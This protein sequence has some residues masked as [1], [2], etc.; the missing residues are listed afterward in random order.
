MVRLTGGHMARSV[1]TGAG[2]STL[3]L[4]H[5][6][7]HHIVFAIDGGDSVSVTQTSELLRP[8]RVEFVDG[9]TQRTLFEYRFPEKLD[10]VLID[11]PHGYPFPEMEYWVLYRHIRQGGL[12]MVDDIHI[13]TINRLFQFLREE[14]MFE[15][16][17]VVGYTAFFRRTAAPT[18]DPYCDGWYEQPFNTARFPVDVAA[19]L[20]SLSTEID[21]RTRL[22]PLVETWNAAGTRVAIFGIGEHTRHLLQA[23][24]EIERLRLVA[25]LDSNPEKQ[26][27]SY[28]G[29]TVR[30]PE[31]AEGN[32]DVVLCSSF[33]HEMTQMA[34]LDH[35]NVK[36]V[37]SHVRSE[38]SGGSPFQTPVAMPA[39]APGA[40][41][42]VVC[43]PTFGY[44]LT[45]PADDR[46]PFA[47][48]IDHFDRELPSMRAF[49]AEVQ[50][51]F[52]ELS[53]I[54]HD[55]VDDVTP[56]WNNG[57]FSWTDA[58]LAYAMVR[59]LKPKRIVEIGSGNSTK[60]MRHAVRANG[61]G[62]EITSIDPAPRAEID[63]I[64]DRVLRTPLQ[65]APRE[66]FDQLAAGDI[67]F[68]DGSHLVFPGSDCVS[69]FLRILPRIAPGVVVHVHDIYLP[70]GYPEEFHERY[71]NEQYLLGAFLLGNSDWRP[72][73]ASAHLNSRGAFADGNSSF[74]M[75]REA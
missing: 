1:E 17:E 11:G 30:A 41:T 51:F 75:I 62:T 65:K 4:S 29:R 63:R 14:P 60:F 20:A 55:S 36:V 35:V 7:D 26:G 46:E 37:P 33:A 15:L 47:A 67:L 8:E 32:C 5:L 42:D 66:T 10:F 18:F 72:L 43:I 27:A 57:Y 28:R 52:G 6:S 70:F 50:A 49:V 34:V 24:P 13:P 39:N 3:L 53:S 71:Y 12:L 74:W 56:H 68:F 22:L 69:F 31:W 19:G 23:V 40:A 2:K 45:S 9:P 44:Q 58:K 73:V 59:H 21:Y 16:V 64:C 38:S 48:L 25:F 61:S 54:P